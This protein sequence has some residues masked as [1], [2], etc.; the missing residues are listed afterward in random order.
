MKRCAF[1]A[2]LISCVVAAPS[3]GAIA[4]SDVTTDLF[5]FTDTN[6][7]IY[8]NATLTGTINDGIAT[9]TGGYGT[10]SAT[11]S[12]A[13]YRYLELVPTTAGSKG[14]QTGVYTSPDG[15]FWFDDLLY[16]NKN[17]SLD[18]WGLLFDVV[19][20]AQGNT[21]VR[22]SH[23][24]PLEVNVWGNAADNYS[25]YDNSGQSKK[26]YFGGGLQ[27]TTSNAST[28]VT[29]VPEPVSMITWSLLAAGGLG[30]RALRRRGSA[31]QRNWSNE[32]RTAIL[33]VI[34]SRCSKS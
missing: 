27:Y 22:N 10:V 25:Y 4:T 5:S 13:P 23:G 33:S 26:G 16:T 8:V 7:N 24:L 11:P 29:A 31:G 17:P 2:A 20:T 21:L 19:T 9:I 6:N 34:E 12:G 32:N 15:S 30:V 28:S 14:P 3:F 18:S 1:L